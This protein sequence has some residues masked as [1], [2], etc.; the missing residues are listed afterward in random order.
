MLLKLSRPLVT[1]PAAGD[2]P[3]Q[4]VTEIDLNF[5]Q[6]TGNDYCIAEMLAVAGSAVVGIAEPRLN[7]AFQVE[8]ASRA[9]GIAPE[10]LRTL[11]LADFGKVCNAVRNFF[12]G[13]D[14]SEET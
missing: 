3:E 6:L 9:C 10:R 5:E 11:G 1:I 13:S 12:A 8:I 14:A 2:R 7:P 4:S